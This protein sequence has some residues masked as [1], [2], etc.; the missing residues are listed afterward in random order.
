MP[1]KRNLSLL[2]GLLSLLGVADAAQAQAPLGSR[3]QGLAGAFVGMAD[4][5]SAVYW[6]PAG[7]ATGAILSA[8]VNIG[9]ETTAPDDPQT[10]AGE[11]HTGTIV[12]FTL[13]PI[14]LAY[15]RH[16]AYGTS[17]LTPAVVGPDGREEVG[18]SVHAVATSTLGV[19][20]LHSLTPWLVVS[21]TPK[22]VWGSTAVGT[23]TAVRSREALDDAADLERSGTTEFD[24][25][26]GVM[27]AYSHIRIGV[28][29]RNLTTPEFEAADGRLVTLAREVRAGVAWG[30]TWPGNT[31]LSVSFDGDIEARPTPFGDRRDIAAGVETWWMGR[32]LGLRGG[33]RRS[34]IGEARAAYA[35]GVTAGVTASVML[36]A[37]VTR[38]DWNERGWSVGMR[39]GF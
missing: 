3:A 37:H 1:N 20:L 22:A 25:D 2:V 9:D 4:D 17:A 39:M 26:A 27:L 15:Y 11:R 29:G 21:A 10:A 32:R 24:V 33:V 8:I 14:G 6:N 38:G 31:N 19:S 5:A 18:R 30:L 28:V 13:P 35:G 7:I 36:E 34:T 12:A 23:S 16:V